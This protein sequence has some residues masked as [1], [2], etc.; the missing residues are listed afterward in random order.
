M[1]QRKQ[2]SVLV[3]HGYW[4]PWGL[5]STFNPEGKVY[6]LPEGLRILLQSQ[7]SLYLAVIMSESAF[8]DIDKRASEVS[9]ELLPRK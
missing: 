7:A 1:I 5:K 3:V 2:S 4:A 6:N 9:E 8:F